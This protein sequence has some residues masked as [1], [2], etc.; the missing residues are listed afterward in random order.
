MLCSHRVF[1]KS[2]MHFQ[3]IHANDF[4]KQYVAALYF[5]T[6]T[7]TTCGFGDI[8]ATQGDNVEALVMTF[9]EFIGLLFYSYSIDKMQTILADSTSKP[10]GEYTANMIE[11]YE[12]LIV[13]V[14]RALE[15]I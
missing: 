7:L 1:D 13:K 15:K 5:V 12:T 8:A 9:L 10:T 3:G 14:G 4:T 2:W 11:E 6:T